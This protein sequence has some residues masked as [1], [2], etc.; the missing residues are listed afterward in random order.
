MSLIARKSKKRSIVKMKPQECITH[1][2]VKFILYLRGEEMVSR[3]GVPFDGDVVWN[4]DGTFS[5]SE[6]AIADVF[7]YLNS[8]WEKYVRANFRKD[9]HGK[10]MDLFKQAV[11]E[12]WKASRITTEQTESQS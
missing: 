9:S 7:R 3:N 10:Y 12:E 8:L 6:K 4:G 1:L 2:F 11:S 5:P